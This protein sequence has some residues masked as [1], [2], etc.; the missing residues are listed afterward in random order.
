MHT[1][2][3]AKASRSPGAAVGGDLCSRSAFSLPQGRAQVR[4]Q[5]DTRD[6]ADVFV[7]VVFWEVPKEGL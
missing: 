2:P 3:Q 7:V 6:Q 1:R 5:G 4:G